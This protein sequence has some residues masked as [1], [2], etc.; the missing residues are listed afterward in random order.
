MSGKWA[1]SH[2]VKEMCVSIALAFV[3]AAGA[4]ACTETV[5]FNVLRPAK[6]N[7]RGMAGEGKDATVTLGEWQGVDASAAEDIKQRLRELVTNS[8][9]GVVKFAQADGVVR[10]DGNV[11]EHSSKEDVTSKQDQ[12]TKSENGKTV[13]YACTRYTRTAK[14]QVRV[15][16][17]VVDKGGKTLAAD[18]FSDSIQDQTTATDEQPPPID[19]DQMLSALRGGAAQKLATLVVP[20]RVQVTKNW[21]KCGDANDA[22][23]A[24]LTQ[25][26]G[27]NFAGA[28]DLLKKAV[29]QLKAAKEPDGKALAGAWWGLTLAQEFSGDYAG[30]R[31][32]LQEAIH[33]NPN[34][35][36]FAGEMLS[37]QKEDS[38]RKQV[39]K[40]VGGE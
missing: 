7:V 12:C 13:Q 17:N 15:S 23:K 29:D 31:A 33:A 27:G 38:S 5:A 28:I 40:Q 8:E 10:L 21:Y 19:R 16:M 25:L 24:A 3:C 14:A 36:D 30:A 34:E 39:T 22:C 26:R 2:G 9:G 35:E 4:S 32:S 37:I 11:A 6:V 20:Y 18:T 1:L